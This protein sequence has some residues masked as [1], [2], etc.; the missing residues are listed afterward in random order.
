MD[1][2]IGH[3][4]C[5]GFR[6]ISF[7]DGT[8]RDFSKSRNP[9]IF[10]DGISLIFSSLDFLEIARD[11][12]GFTFFDA[13]SDYLEYFSQANKCFRSNLEYYQRK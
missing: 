12:S 8:G 3:N 7:Q 5:P 9:G 11:F 1:K 2:Q 13:I 10:R 4:Q 6:G